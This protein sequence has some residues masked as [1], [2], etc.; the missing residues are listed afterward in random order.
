[1]KEA[2]MLQCTVEQNGIY[3]NRD[4]RIRDDHCCRLRPYID[5]V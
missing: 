3:V 4:Q 2:I 1:V 5:I